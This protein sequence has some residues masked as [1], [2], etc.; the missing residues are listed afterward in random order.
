[1]IRISPRLSRPWIALAASIFFLSATYA[2]LPGPNA[3]APGARRAA[4]ART[5]GC[6]RSLALGNWGADLGCPR[7]LAL[8]DRGASARGH[9]PSSTQSPSPASP[10]RVTLDNGQLTIE[11][12]NSD[13]GQIL[14]EVARLSGI[15]ITGLNGGPRV[16]GVYGPDTPRAVLASLLTASGYNFL[17]VGGCAVP[18]Q[19][20]LT[21]ETK[22]AIASS[23]P[24]PPPHSDSYNG[25]D[26][27]QPDY[28]DSP[29]P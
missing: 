6:H 4:L 10:A 22:A 26:Y 3:A 18:T 24:N 17:L 23:Q 8:G 5:V 19:L 21:P 27:P 25:D 2:Q 7:S 11:A 20:I 14:Q 15:A 12:Q 1:M 9:A 29:Q 28:S 13:L 16:F